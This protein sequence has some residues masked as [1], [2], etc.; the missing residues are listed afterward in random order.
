MIEWRAHDLVT[1]PFHPVPRSVEGSKYVAL[2]FRRK[3]V[4]GVKA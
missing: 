1:G 4:A 3:L 2:V